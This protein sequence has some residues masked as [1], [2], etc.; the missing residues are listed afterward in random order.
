LTKRLYG[1][2]KLDGTDN[3][4]PGVVY[5]NGRKKIASS[6]EFFKEHIVK[7]SIKDDKL[8]D[9]ELYMNSI[10]ATRFS[11]KNDTIVAFDKMVEAVLPKNLFQDI[12]MLSEVSTDDLPLGI[13]ITK[14]TVTKINLTEDKVKSNVVEVM[15]LA[16]S[17]EG[18]D[19]TKLDIDNI[20]P[21][22]IW[23]PKNIEL[24]FGVGSD[25]MVMVQK[26]TSTDKEGNTVNNYNGLG[27]YVLVNTGPVNKPKPITNTSA[28]DNS[29]MVEKTPE[30][31]APAPGAPTGDVWT[32][33]SD[34]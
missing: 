27:I 20:E 17:L 24:N 1:V 9:D 23:V 21:I 5:L 12:G 30:A 14:A 6:P 7:L 10:S 28:E 26:S 3:W 29:S 18:T 13:A 4:K 22:T 25:V 16:E 32:P 2:F 34:K 15:S 11:K 19:I 8:A 33:G 31:V